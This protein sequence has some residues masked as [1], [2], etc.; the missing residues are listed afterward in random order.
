MVQVASLVHRAP[1]RLHV[2][3]FLVATGRVVVAGLDGLLAGLI[4]GFIVLTAVGAPANHIGFPWPMEIVLTGVAVSAVALAGA[5][6]AFGVT[7]GIV[8]VGRQ[9]TGPLEARGHHRLAMFVGLPFRFVGAL[10]AALIGAFAVL[11]WIALMGRTIGPLGLLTPPGVLS[12][13]IY[14][15]GAVGVLVAMARAI[16]V[17]RD[18][19]VGVG[20]G[21][22]RRLLGGSVAVG[23][24]TL[25]IGTVAYAW[26]PGTTDGMVAYDPTFDGDPVAAD[27]VAATTAS[28]DDPGAPG[29]Y[30][31]ERWSYG[32]G[33]DAR[34]PAFGADAA[35]ITPTVDASGALRR[36]SE[37]ADATRALWWGFGT[38]ALPLNALVWAP[39]GEGPFPLVLIVH[40]NHAM[41]DFSED[42]YAYLG[43]HLASRGFIT[44]SIDEDFLNGS[45][46]DDW[47]GDEQAVRAW[48][49]L[50]HVDQWR[51]WG[52]DPGDTL[53]G[54]VDLDRVAL[55][56]HSR[57]GEAS[58]VAAGLSLTDVAPRSSMAPW[59][60]D[61]RIRTVVAIAPSDGQYGSG[62]G[63]T[64]VDFLTIAGGHDADA[65]SWAG[66]RQYARTTVDDDDFKAAL[67]TYR[68]NH[69]QF[70]TVWGR[71]DFGPFSG[72]QLN[73]APLLPA[74]DQEDVAKTTIGAF[75]EASLHD[76]DAYRG[77]FKRPM[78]GREWL[79]ED[80]YL[81]RSSHGGVVPLTT[82]DPATP[83]TGV[84]IESA[85]F[86]SV[87]A[88]HV[89]LRALLPDQATRALIARWSRG[90]GDA[91]WTVRGLDTVVPE[92]TAATTIRFAL[93]DGTRTDEGP[94]PPLRIVVEAIA[95]DG[96]T[97]AL[98]LD[99]VGALPPPLPVR[100]AK[101]EALFAT[102]G[103]DIHLASP[104]ERVLQTYEIPFGAFEAIDP[105]LSA[106]EV[107][108]F[109]LR[110][111][112][113][114]PGSI[115]IGD[116]GVGG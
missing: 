54:R 31:V 41:G 76:A 95:A 15:A 21:R 99:E 32:S 72:S 107:V 61:L 28:I 4:V 94:T 98:P 101:H 96:S 26:Y 116:V 48:L 42:G 102:S 90:D 108:G 38:E 47:S 80:I 59:P 30:E 85:G 106:S 114:H 19:P 92:R 52:A 67:W 77:F 9:L 89:P 33:T 75:L 2:P 104:V 60:R 13:F 39:M 82:D 93:A 97:V 27:A 14:V 35:R 40:G 55:I 83:A 7:A 1:L 78:L 103:I 62:V 24:A 58:A 43:E 45:W 69:G 86:A 34:R 53:H 63:L 111:D 56:G 100:L 49:L 112:R 51:S 16:L 46:A 23:A 66:I 25:V 65:R 87:G 17:P 79:P 88:M 81:V 12:T 5:A 64:G 3:H 74:A 8:W 20:P 68:A 44:A 11:L 36:L 18:L 57:G 115:W 113:V 73:L 110:I 84:A 109:R 50:L 10:P 91:T 6:V 70:N 29:P 22:A 71:G 105:D 37:G